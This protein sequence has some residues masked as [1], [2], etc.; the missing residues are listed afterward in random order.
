MLP[1]T[2]Y[3]SIS[4]RIEAWVTGLDNLLEKLDHENVSAWERS[5][6]IALRNERFYNPKFY[7]GRTRSKFGL[8]VEDN[9]SKANLVLDEVLDFCIYSSACKTLNMSFTDFMKL[10][11]ATYRHIREKIN[12]KDEKVSKSQKALMEKQDK[13]MD[14]LKT[15]MKGVQKQNVSKST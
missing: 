15:N 5:H 3:G 11:L 4:D 6:A 13:L 12:E 7:S 9:L 10:D 14:N 8:D 1:E 2:G